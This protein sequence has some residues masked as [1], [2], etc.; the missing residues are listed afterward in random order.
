MWK[1]GQENKKLRSMLIHYLGEL[2]LHYSR[3][4]SK[5]LCENLIEKLE[6]ENF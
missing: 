2:K 3:Q 5:R 4:D 1:V 6:N